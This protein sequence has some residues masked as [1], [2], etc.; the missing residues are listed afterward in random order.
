[1]CKKSMNYRTFVT[2]DYP[3]AVQYEVSATDG[4]FLSAIMHCGGD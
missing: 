2:F 1:M 4:A 3:A